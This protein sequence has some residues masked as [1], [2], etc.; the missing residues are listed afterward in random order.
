MMIAKQF[1]E[2]YIPALE[3]AL[4]NDYINYVYMVN[5]PEYYIADEYQDGIEELLHIPMTISFSLIWLAFT[6][7][8][9]PIIF[10]LYRV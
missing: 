5:G 1:Y 3:S 7:M 4:V 9:N 2:I 6:L 8:P 10:P